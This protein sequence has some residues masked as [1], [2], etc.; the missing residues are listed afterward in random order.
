MGKLTMEPERV[1]Y[2]FEQICSIPHGSGNTKQISDYCVNFAKE[3]SLEYVQDEKNN[4]IIWKG[5]T[6]GRET[7][8][9]LIIQ[10]HLDMVCEKNL[11][12]GHDF[13]KE[14]IRLLT[15]GEWIS[16]D[17]TTLG[18]DDGIAAA[19][20]FAILESK[21]ISHPPL[22]VVL[23]VDEEIGMLGAAAL[24]TSVLKGNRVLNIDSEE[25]G[26]LLASCA[27]GVRINGQLPL[28]YNDNSYD[29]MLHITVTGLLGGHSGT[30]I[31]KGRCNAIKLIGRLLFELEQKFDYGIAHISGGLQDNAIPREAQVRIAL[32]ETD[33]ASVRQ[34]IS[35]FC[36]KMRM[37]LGAK[38]PDLCINVLEAEK[39]EKILVPSS[40]Q[41]VIFLLVQAPDGVQEMSGEIE[42]LVETSLNLGIV[43][44]D[45]HTFEMSFALRS[46]VQT[47]KEALRDRLAYLIE[48]TGGECYAEG[49]Y[50]AWEYRKESAFRQSCVQAY[51]HIYGKEPKV[52]ALHAGLECGILADKIDGFDAVSIGPDIYDIHTPSEKMNIAS[53]QRTWKYI[54]DILKCV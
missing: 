23:T 42:N 31:D 32:H 45:E 51:Q 33:S 26:V 4:I 44:T 47:A 11:D 30:E 2:Y 17:G 19:Y 54:L 50:P 10:G 20:A 24:D 35:L 7:Q 18:G 41:L 13:E 53:V 27:G 29:R 15:D 9:P 12:C 14:G 40:K 37:E 16:A 8:A 39:Q 25:E 21:D 49:D 28:M 5:G 34:Y 3:H 6:Q 52:M 46:S 43:K 48:F 22:E 1:F 38:E 36:D